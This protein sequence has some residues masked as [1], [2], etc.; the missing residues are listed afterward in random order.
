MS[1][2]NLSPAARLPGGGRPADDQAAMNQPVDPQDL[3]EHLV[4]PTQMPP[5]GAKV[6]RAAVDAIGGTARADAMVDAAEE[7]RIDVLSSKDAPA[8]G[9]TTWSTVSLHV[10]Q[11]RIPLADG[12]FKDI[13]AELMVVGA[14]GSDVMGRVLGSSAF[15]VL[16]DHWLM[17][18]GIVFGEVVSMYEPTTTTPHLL[19][20]HP[21]TA[22]ELDRVEVDDMAVHWLLGVP[23]SEAERVWLETNGF[24]ALTDLF[25]SRAVVYT[26]LQRESV[27]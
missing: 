19:W 6:A 27:V 9:W 5:T 11:N 10:E 12:T 14:P 25:E 7:H 23:I 13:R 8:P 20:C 16:Q 4:A 2:D 18:P 21:F 17:A 1:D 22:P 24:E 3:P 26:D 15:A